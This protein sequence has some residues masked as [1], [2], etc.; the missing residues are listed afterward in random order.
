M[1]LNYASLITV[2]FF[3]FWCVDVVVVVFTI[4]YCL[5]FTVAFGLHMR[6]VVVVCVF[7]TFFPLIVPINFIASSLYHVL[8]S[9]DCL[10]DTHT[11]THT[12][13]AARHYK[14]SQ[15]HILT[16]CQCVCVCVWVC[17]NVC[18]PAAML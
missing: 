18:V 17:V 6:L 9:F 13:V 16:Q 14:R 4:K 15:T 1:L 5:S 8:E 3:V 12:L 7:S 10:T 11:H 2:G